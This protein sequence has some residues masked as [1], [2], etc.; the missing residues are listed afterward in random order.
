MKQITPVL[1]AILALTALSG[2]NSDDELPE[3]TATYPVVEVSR[4]LDVA[5][6]VNNASVRLEIGYEFVPQV[7]G[8]LQSITGVLPFTGVVQV[9]LWESFTQT[10]IAT[11]EVEFFTNIYQET[12]IQNPISLTAEKSYMLTFNTID[13]YVYAPPSEGKIFPQT[14]GDVEIVRFG[15]K[16][17]FQPEFPTNFSDNQMYGLIDFRFEPVP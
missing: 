13:Y 10:N 4:P 8:Q 11:W 7:D 16:T 1:I 14:I 9:S 17:A 12:F 6:T 5:D 3:V 2:C 15:T